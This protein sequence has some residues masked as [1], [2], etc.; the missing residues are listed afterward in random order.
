MGRRPGPLLTFL[1]ICSL[2]D[3]GG[4]R[5]G[6]DLGQEGG[7]AEEQVGPPELHAAGRRAVALGRAAGL[8]QLPRD[9]RPGNLP[10]LAA[11]APAKQ[12]TTPQRGGW[13]LRASSPG[14]AP[15]L[16]LPSETSPR[17]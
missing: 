11:G 5:L 10:D 17:I 4:G 9:L 7:E 6:G 3:L 2:L 14:P 12:N 13:E 16:A 15:A 1:G 8:Q